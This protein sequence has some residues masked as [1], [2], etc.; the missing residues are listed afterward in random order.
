MWHS[1]RLAVVNWVQLLC[2][3]ACICVC[4]RERERI[5]VCVLVCDRERGKLFQFMYIPKYIVICMN[6]R[7]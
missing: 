6:C 7:T 4:E 1:F 2:V 3:C 5:C